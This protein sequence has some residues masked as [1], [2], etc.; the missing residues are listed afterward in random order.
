MFG[1]TQIV[2]EATRIST[3]DTCIENIFTN[4]RKNIEVIKVII[5]PHFSDHLA[6]FTSITLKSAVTEL[7]NKSQCI[8]TINKNQIQLFKSM[9]S[10]VHWNQVLYSA[11]PKKFTTLH[12]IIET[13]FNI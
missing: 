5:E 12:N 13:T 1:L 2:K 7:E 6:Q 11:A 10:E 8:R 9:L 4:S 3:I